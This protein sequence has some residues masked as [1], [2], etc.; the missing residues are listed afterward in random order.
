MQAVCYYR[1]CRVL[2]LVLVVV[3]AAKGLYFIA[4]LGY[5]RRDA[6]HSLRYCCCFRCYRCYLLPLMSMRLVRCLHSELD[7]AGHTYALETPLLL[8]SDEIVADVELSQRP[9]VGEI[10]MK[11]TSTV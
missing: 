3:T 5:C 2:S 7:A 4:D 1:L 9:I 11:Y 8:S 6:G 10:L